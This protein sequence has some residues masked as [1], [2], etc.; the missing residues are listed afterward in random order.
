MQKLNQLRVLL[1]VKQVYQGFNWRYHDLNKGKG[2][3]YKP[4]LKDV[5]SLL[6]ADVKRPG[7]S[8]VLAK[9]LS[10]LGNFIVL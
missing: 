5:I 9:M 7:P 2:N 3:N 8:Q 4:P 1:T 6:E 10:A